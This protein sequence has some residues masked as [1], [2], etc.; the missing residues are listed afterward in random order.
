MVAD[1]RPAAVLPRHRDAHRSVAAPGARRTSRRGGRTRRTGSASGSDR[2]TPRA[3][4]RAQSAASRSRAG[5]WWNLRGTTPELR[6]S[7]GRFRPVRTASRPRS[8]RS[9]AVRSSACSRST[10]ACAPAASPGTASSLRSPASSP[11][12]SGPPRR[13]DRAHRLLPVGGPGPQAAGTRDLTMATPAD[14]GITLVPRPALA[15]STNQG[16][17]VPNPRI[18][19]LRTPTPRP[20]AP[21]HRPPFSAPPGRRP[22]L[23]T[24]Q[25]HAISVGDVVQRVLLQVTAA[26][27]EPAREPPG[28]H[29]TGGLPEL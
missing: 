11:A 18:I 15:G 24:R 19:R 8:W 23:P 2:A 26:V 10:A 4:G 29:D 12:S 17:G 21:A 14:A 6:G 22:P 3:R 16:P 9:R 7:A 20:G 5:C 28:A 13:T 27:A 25:I 1:R